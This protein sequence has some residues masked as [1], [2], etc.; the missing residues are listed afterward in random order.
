MLTTENYEVIKFIEHG[1]KCR[2]IM[3]C[4]SGRLLCERLKDPTGITKEKIYKWF[5]MLAL[6]LEKYR[7][8][9]SGQCYRYI[10]PY[11]ILVTH[12]DKIRLLDLSAQSNAFVLK[13]MQ[14]YPMREHFV[15]P[16]IH[17]H[18][19]I[20][21]A[22]GLYGFGKTIQFILAYTEGS[23]S[24][25]KREEHLLSVI[26]E[27]CLGESPKRKYENLTQL[28]KELQKITLKKQKKR[29]NKQQ[30]K[31]IFTVLGI[32]LI[33]FGICTLKAVARE[34]GI[35]D[36]ERERIVNLPKE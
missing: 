19:N 36:S 5:H 2:I 31:T 35:T 12:Q 13:N 27:K 1:G 6:E 4:A 25:S 34:E 22:A 21:L 29:Q 30:K 33:L 14:R 18:D 9:K 7:R 17:I 15:K 20:G 16:V 23:I 26:I 32:V 11:S 10:N 24:H 3:D 28:Q 8:C